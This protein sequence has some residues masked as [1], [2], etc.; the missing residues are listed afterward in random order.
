MLDFALIQINHIIRGSKKQN[1]HK[2][3]K[4]IIMLKSYNTEFF[5]KLKQSLLP[6]F[7]VHIA[8]ALSSVGRWFGRSIKFSC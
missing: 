4:K 5:R 3:I 6:F 2:E 8:F 7:V 1:L